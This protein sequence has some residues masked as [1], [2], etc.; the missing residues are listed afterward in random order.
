M[1]AR[2]S[3]I[4]L[5]N[6]WEFTKLLMQIRNIFCNTFRYFYKAIIHRKSVIYVFTV[7]NINFY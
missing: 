5:A 2:K 6:G 3:S 4:G 7:A 1:L